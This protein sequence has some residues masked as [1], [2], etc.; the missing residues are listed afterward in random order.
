M[1]LKNVSEIDPMVHM[2][3][4]QRDVDR[5]DLSPK[6]GIPSTAPVSEFPRRFLGRYKEAGKGMRRGIKDGVAPRTKVPLGV[7]RRK[8]DG[9]KTIEISRDEEKELGGTT[10]PR[11]TSRYKLKV[12][13]AAKIVNPSCHYP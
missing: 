5:F 13:T 8:L 10:A 11:R 2:G 12:L 7:R 6:K 1:R 3:F 4:H 9:S